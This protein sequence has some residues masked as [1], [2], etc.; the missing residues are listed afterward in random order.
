MNKDIPLIQAGTS[1]YNISDG[2]YN[3]FLPAIIKRVLEDDK[4]HLECVRSDGILKASIDELHAKL[5]EA[6]GRLV[7]R[8]KGSFSY[9]W[10]PNGLAGSLF[11][12]HCSDKKKSIGLH[13]T[14]TDPRLM[15]LVKDL[16]EHF[17]SKSKKDYAFV[18]VK[19][20]QYF[21][22]KNLGDASSPL[23]PLNY[24]PS[25]IENVG[26]V[27]RAWA[28]DP[29]VGR[30]TLMH[31]APGTGK[32][33]LIRSIIGELDNVFLI[34]PP[35][36]VSSLDSPDLV[37]LIMSVQKEHEKPIT[38]I[39]EDGD[40]CLLPRESD[41]MSVIASLLNMGDGILG[42]LM[43]IRIIITTNAEL[44]KI[45]SAIT[46][47]GRLC[48]NIYV[49]PLSFKRAND[50]YHRLL[51]NNG[52]NLKANETYTLAE[53]YDVVNKGKLGAS[54]SEFVESSERR[55]M[56]FHQ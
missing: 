28:Q 26:F 27:L 44:K 10:H 41:N 33:H 48:Q 2:A 3:I 16:E 20:G 43:D 7:H 4:I 39:V 13:A 42:T 47:P 23:I 30:V 38:F 34:V 9:L 46:R 32:T 12:F 56:G 50:V 15:E 54:A 37:P 1:N 17:I 31:G 45:D 11:D 6:G 14:I 21:D 5:K 53:V 29:P 51:G 18:I 35:S 22:M 55:A 8:S 52:K 24:E 36:I 19:E 49:P 25:V 40:Q